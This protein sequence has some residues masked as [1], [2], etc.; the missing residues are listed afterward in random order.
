MFNPDYRITP[1]LLNL[2]TGIAAAREA[3]ANAYLVPRWEVSLR[4]QALIKNAHASTAIEGNPLTLEQVSALAEG[5]DV[6]AQRKAKQE[7]L[8]YLEVLEKLP[9]LAPKAEIIE[10][11]ILEI[12]RLLAKEVLDNPGDVGRYRDR[13]V[14]V[15]HRMTGEI[16]FLPPETADVPRL[17][18]AFVEWL[19]DKST[20]ELDPVIEAGIAHYEFVRIHPFIDGNGR[21]ARVLA[22]LILYRRGFDTKRF[23]ALDDYYDSD[24]LE[25]YHALQSVDPKSRD[26]TAWLEYFAQGVMV[27]VQAVRERALK[28]SA[29]KRKAGKRGQ[30]A[31]TERQ[32]KIIER[33]HDQGQITNR[34]IRE[35]FDLS[36]RVAL[37]EINKLMDLGVVR[38]EGQ[39]RTT[40]YILA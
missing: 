23:F 12:H 5:R 35:M 16:V 14:G 36:N 10:S 27:S 6:M 21:A 11:I 4:K 30:I 18:A 1:K 20:R 34:E 37:D 19:N 22:A 31:L 2:L 28:L 38:S 40:H 8:N 17:M 29:D 25:Y 15:V 13:Q 24:R 3:I 39:G 33:I 7:V 26:L 32:M 9:R